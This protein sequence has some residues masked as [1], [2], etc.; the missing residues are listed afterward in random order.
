M[1]LPVWQMGFTEQLLLALWGFV[2][3]LLRAVT[4]DFA[5]FWIVY[6]VDMVQVVVELAFELGGR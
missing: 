6:L 2:E 4:H 1:K 3:K 5:F